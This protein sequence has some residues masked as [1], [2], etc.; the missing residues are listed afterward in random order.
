MSHPTGNGGPIDSVKVADFDA[1]TRRA[2]TTSPRKLYVLVAHYDGAAPQIKV[3][4]YSRGPTPAE[5]AGIPAA[6]SG[7]PYIIGVLPPRVSRVHRLP[8][9]AG[10]DPYPQI[11]GGRLV[12]AIRDGVVTFDWVDPRPVAY[13]DEFPRLGYVLETTPTTC[14][15]Q[16]D[17]TFL[18]ENS[19]A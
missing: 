16:L 7:T 17:M 18:A 11:A 8:D 6:A 19:F 10:L 4:P 1:A 3:V 9:A 15:L 13:G 14:T 2:V 12:P 5:L